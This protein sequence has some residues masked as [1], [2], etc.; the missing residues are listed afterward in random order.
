M[1]ESPHDTIFSFCS[2]YELQAG[3]VLRGAYLIHL[4]FVA[5]SRYPILLAMFASRSVSTH[6]Y[7]GQSVLGNVLISVAAKIRVKGHFSLSHSYP[8][9]A[10]CSR[11]NAGVVPPLAN[12]SALKKISTLAGYTCPWLFLFSYF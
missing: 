8:V 6:I 9:T 7:C 4:F 5:F 3:A 12:F 2:L 10:L 11:G 1:V